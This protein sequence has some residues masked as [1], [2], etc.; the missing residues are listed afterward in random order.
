M[1]WIAEFFLLKD[2]NVRIVVPGVLI[3]CGMSAM[4][5]CFT[6][7][8]KRSLM[9]D[10]ISHSVLP[11]IC[12][13][14]ML[15]GEKNPIYFLIGAMITGLLSVLLMELLTRSSLVRNDTAI[16][17]LLSVF[18]GAG[19]V[20]LTFIQHEGNASQAGLDTFL[21]GKAASLTRADLFLFIAS[22]AVIVSFILVF[23]RGLTLLSFDEDFAKASGFPVKFLRLALSVITVWSVAI[24]IQAVGVVLMAALLIAP[25]LAARFWTNQ[26]GFM[27]L[28]ATLI[29]MFSGYSGAFISYAAPQMPTGPWIVVVAGIVALISMFFSPKRGMMFQ[30]LE[31]RRNG[32]KMLRENLLKAFYHIYE[33]KSAGKPVPV[34]VDDL[35]NQRALPE[36]DLKRGLRMLEQAGM[37]EFDLGA[38]KLN[39][40]GMQEASR[41][42]RLHRLWEL[43]LQEYLH[44]DP[45]H[46][47]DDAEAMEHVIT[48]EIEA[49]LV[50][51]LGNPTK[52][53]HHTTIPSR[54]E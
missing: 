23:L 40:H 26:L 38:W 7:L 30:W 39:D 12:L 41:V 10:A 43:Y 35:V 9:A 36:Y 44:L 6:F 42:V 27:L 13:A 48:P 15:T 37:L 54:H 28:L 29:G 53:P 25:A 31:L 5:G 2:P 47:H 21:F 1:N 49:Q 8:R 3:L 16:A 17:L 45:D 4:V 32:A 18:F 34:L 33:K 19:I 22:A 52:D 20:L 24:G 51:I 14:F 46:V 50:E 11:G